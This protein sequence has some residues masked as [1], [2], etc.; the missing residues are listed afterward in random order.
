MQTWE[1][2]QHLQNSWGKNPLVAAS[3]E[4]LP[5]TNVYL[6]NQ[7]TAEKSMQ[8]GLSSPP[9]LTPAAQGHQVWVVSQPTVLRNRTAEGIICSLFASEVCLGQSLEGTKPARR[10]ELL[11]EVFSLWQQKTPLNFSSEGEVKTEH[12]SSRNSPL[13]TSHS[14]WLCGG[15]LVVTDFLSL[16]P[17]ESR[18]TR[19]Q[20]LRSRVFASLHIGNQ[21][22]HHSCFQPILWKREQGRKTWCQ[23]W[24]DVT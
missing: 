16:L 1:A 17:P 10:K 19:L 12:T 15:P 24:D 3:A 13:R 18:K 4:V 21:R 6:H 14:T 23:I 8:H 20:V 22:A 9:L 2:G 11:Q 7:P 5:P